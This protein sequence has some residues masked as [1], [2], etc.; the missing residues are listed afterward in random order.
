MY[1]L[2]ACEKSA[3]CISGV[4]SLKT[5]CHVRMGR[6]GAVQE[7]APEVLCRGKQQRGDCTAGSAM[8]DAAIAPLHNRYARRACGCKRASNSRSVS[9]LHRLAPAGRACSGSTSCWRLWTTT[10]SCLTAASRCACGCSAMPLR[11]E[12][13]HCACFGSVVTV[14]YSKHSSIVGVH[15]LLD[16]S[17]SASIVRK[18]ALCKQLASCSVS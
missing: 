16:T 17:T 13:W 18:S 14:Y 8:Q 3:I 5:V 1:L 2:Q 12:T 9:T 11:I 15:T 7:A 4:G 10:P 6:S